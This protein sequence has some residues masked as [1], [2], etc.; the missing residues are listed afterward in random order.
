MNSTEHDASGGYLGDS[1]LLS[2]STH[3]FV[4]AS[5]T[6]CKAITHDA[7]WVTWLLY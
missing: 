6:S 5:I 4:S 3:D 7:S 1:S 2:H